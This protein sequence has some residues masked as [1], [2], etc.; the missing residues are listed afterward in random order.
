MAEIK[1]EGIAKL[2]KGLK[3]RMDMSAVKTT[4]R[5]NGKSMESKAKR[6]AVFKGHYAW[7]EGKGMVFKKPT[8]NLKRSIGLEISPNGLKATVEPKAEYAA[9]VELG[10]RKMEAQPY[11]RP[12]F[13]EQKKQFEKDL[14][15]L[16]K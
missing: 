10:T 1:F 9:Y 15:E 4:V 13:E 5:K 12:A 6:N 2:N 14:K 11:L 16:V 7:E 3:K 8:G